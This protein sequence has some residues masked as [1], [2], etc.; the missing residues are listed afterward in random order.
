MPASIKEWLANKAIEN[1]IKEVKSIKKIKPFDLNKV[2]K[3]SLISIGLPA[4]I[5]SIYC[6]YRKKNKR[7]QQKK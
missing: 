4:K 6:S 3:D 7:L 2:S 1:S 5:A